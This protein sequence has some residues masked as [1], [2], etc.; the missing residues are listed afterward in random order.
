MNCRGFF[1]SSV[2]LPCILVALG[3]AACSS[4]STS[5]TAPAGGQDASG[6]DAATIDAAKVDSSADATAASGISG[7]WSSNFGGYE[8][9]SDKA[10]N[11]MIVT[12]L[13]LATR[14]AITQNSASDKYNPGKFN[15]IVFTTPKD[16]SFYYC[17]VDFGLGSA[18]L[19]EASTK[20]ADDGKPEKTGCGG[21][22]WAKLTHAD[23]IAISG[24]WTN[25]FGE[26]EVISSRTWNAMMVSLFDNQKR[27]AIT[28]NPPDDKYNP[29][30]YS[31]LVWTVPSAAGFYYCTVDY[32]LDSLTLAQDSTKTADDSKPDKG[33]CAGFS[34][35][36]VSP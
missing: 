16:G 25:G 6:G 14:I 23:P 7:T 34:W 33:G 30:K 24:S 27:W 18:D 13:D 20:T 31:K 1:C 26:K 22:S 9:I 8:E 29:S 19:A 36:K 35:T 4:S 15:K 11:D 10:W 5:T 21:F 17:Y 32:G 12:K 28:Q 2:L 3:G